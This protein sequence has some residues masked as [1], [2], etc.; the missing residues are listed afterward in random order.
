M[1]LELHKIDIRRLRFGDST[2]VEQG[3]LSINTGELNTLLLEDERVASVAFVLAHPGESM[4]IM[5]VKDAIEP[6]C[7]LEGPGEVFPGFVGPVEESVGQG[8]TLVLEG[9]AVLTTGRLLAA[10]EGIVDMSGPGAEYTHFSRTCNLVLLIT[11]LITL[12]LHE[13]EEACRIAGLKA[14]QYL[15]S[16]CKG[17]R[18]DRV[19]SYAFAPLNEAM[20]AFPDLHKVVY[21]YMLQSQGL[22]H[23][24]WVY[25]VDAKRI[26]PTIISPTEVMDGAVV[27]G[28]CVSACDK[29]N[30]YVHLNNPIIRALYKRH[31][32]ELNFVGVV[33][34]NENVTLADKQRSSSYAVK[35]A[36]MLGAEA[37]I[38]SEEGFGNPDADLVLNCVKAERAGIKT[39]LVTD[40]YAGANGASQSLADSCPEGT[41]VVTAGNAN[42]TIILPPMDMVVGD[43]ARAD[44]IA[45]GFFGS[46]R[47]DGSLEVEI[48][49]ILGAT[50]ELGFS[51][52]GAYTI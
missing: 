18:A 36:R 37:A 19:E 31:G 27:S 23:D 29:N 1:E 13:A 52:I 42:Q 43:D 32:K 46:R 41:A 8:K 5:P 34:T 17:A 33:L 48:Q 4:R 50:N 28:N 21:I 16:K 30:T 14:A 44:V 6:R 3:V 20:L 12:K 7:K 39:V 26:L 40:E 45:G 15:A 49:A 24:T 51:R 10:Q 38:I 22:L 25:G 47:P 11:P 2:G 9:M 35:L